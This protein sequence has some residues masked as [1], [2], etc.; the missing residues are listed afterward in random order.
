M[1]LGSV[2]SAVWGVLVSGCVPWFFFFYLFTVRV[3]NV[4]DEKL[5]P[6]FI[7]YRQNT[8]FYWIIVN[9]QVR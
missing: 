8:K 4:S 5:L 2:T 1:T 9:D 6:F 7:H 3:F